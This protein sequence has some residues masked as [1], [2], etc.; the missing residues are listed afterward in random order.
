MSKRRAETTATELNEIPFVPVD[1]IKTGSE[2]R[3]RLFAAIA[4]KAEYV[5][6][7]WL[8]TTLGV[9]RASLPSLTSRYG[10]S[11]KSAVTK[12]GI[13][14]IRLSIKESE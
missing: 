11:L 2:D 12:D 8:L 3:I 10:Y 13:K 4:A 7:E 6:T 5:P 1:Q 14:V 9:K